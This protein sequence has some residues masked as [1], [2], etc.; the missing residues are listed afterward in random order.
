[1]IRRRA[2]LAVLVL[3]AMSTWAAVVAGPTWDRS[4]AEATTAA[5]C[6]T[7]DAHWSMEAS[8]IRYGTSHFGVTVCAQPDG[9]IT[10]ARAFLEGGVEGV[11]TPT[12]WLWESRGAW[13]DRQNRT[14][15]RAVGEAKA[16]L[17]LAHYV[18]LCSLT[19]TQQ[20]E[21]RVQTAAG[22]YADGTEPGGPWARVTWCS[23]TGCTH[24][25]TEFV[26][27]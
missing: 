12:G 9:T 25:G 27:A 14:Y 21:V 13:I 2:T 17:C 5:A 23:M 3:L 19:E 1:M 24:D 8:G 4:E 10:S 26:P 18:P 6:R 11:G 22:P 7:T 15:V 16:K 20:F